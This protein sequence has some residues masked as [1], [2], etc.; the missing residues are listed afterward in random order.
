VAQSLCIFAHAKP[1]WLNHFAS[2]LTQNPRGSITLHLRSR[3]TRVAHQFQYPAARP[4]LD[5]EG[6]SHSVTHSQTHKIRPLCARQMSYHKMLTFQPN[7]KQHTRQKFDNN[8]FGVPF[9]RHKI[10]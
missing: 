10:D 4:V 8:A 9:F 5:A 6:Y 7:S 3:K 1:A 2:S